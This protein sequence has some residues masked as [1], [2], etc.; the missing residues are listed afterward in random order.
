MMVFVAKASIFY[1]V[2]HKNDVFC[3]Q[4]QH[5]SWGRPHISRYFV[6]SLNQGTNGRLQKDGD[7]PPAYRTGPD[8]SAGTRTPSL[9]SAGCRSLTEI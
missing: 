9:H 7:V 4:G 6:A 3:G 1:G 5:F 8:G 2:G